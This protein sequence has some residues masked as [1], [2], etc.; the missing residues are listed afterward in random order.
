MTWRRT[1]GVQGPT[2]GGRSL[3]L[4]TV[5]G[6]LHTSCPDAMTAHRKKDWRRHLYQYKYIVQSSMTHL[7]HLYMIYVHATKRG[8]EGRMKPSKILQTVI[9][10]II[11]VIFCKANSFYV[12]YHIIFHGYPPHIAFS[13]I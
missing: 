8:E 3:Y 7:M 1:W 4:S 9:I 10:I 5:D 2:T 6:G 11:E 13:I 12:S